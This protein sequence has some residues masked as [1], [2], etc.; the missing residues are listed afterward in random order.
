MNKITKDKSLIE[1]IQSVVSKLVKEYIKEEEVIVIMYG[2]N[3][4]WAVQLYPKQPNLDIVETL[5]TSF[6]LQIKTL[7]DKLQKEE[8]NKKRE[9]YTV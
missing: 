1:K 8:E 2:S 9:P 4:R 7:K 5:T 3:T 6:L